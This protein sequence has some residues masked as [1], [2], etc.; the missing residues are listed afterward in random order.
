MVL[1]LWLVACL[2]GISAGAL[3]GFG[4][5]K[6]ES[7]NDSESLFIAL[8]VALPLGAILTGLSACMESYKMFDDIAR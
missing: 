1:A 2:L 7:N 5:A 4:V 8:C 6:S 3:I